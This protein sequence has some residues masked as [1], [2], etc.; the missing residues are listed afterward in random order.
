MSIKRNKTNATRLVVI[1][2]VAFVI[3]LFTAAVCIFANTGN[4]YSMAAEKMDFGPT[5]KLEDFKSLD[6]MAM[7]KTDT[8][9]MYRTLGTENSMDLNGLEKS[10]LGPKIDGIN[11][12]DAQVPEPATITLL[13][14]GGLAILRKGRK[15]RKQN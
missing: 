9:E 5:Y 15:N 13:T 11:G 6:G 2:S 7:A 14:L 3:M 1:S 8:I 4:D 12:Q 10:V